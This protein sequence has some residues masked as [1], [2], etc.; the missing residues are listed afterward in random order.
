MQQPFDQIAIDYDK[1]FTDTLV[2]K[3]QRDLVWS[4]LEKVLK[5][6]KITNVLEINCGTGEDALWLSQKGLNVIATDISEKMIES[7]NFKEKNN[8]NLVFQ[9]A[10]FQYISSFFPNKKFD[11]I[12]SNFGGINCTS[13]SNLRDWLNIEIPKMLNPNG[14]L[15]LVIMP[16]FC[17]IESI[18]F[19]GKLQFKNIFRRLSKKP[20]EAKLD[21]E[22]SIKTW[23]YSPKFIKKHLPKNLEIIDIQPI[24]FFIP[25][26]YL[27]SFV[28]KR[29]NLFKI[30][31]KLEK[32]VNLYSFLANFSDHYLIDIQMKK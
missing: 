18:Y 24:G 8:L 9:V 20:L 12:F 30:L 4:Y 13:P 17:L 22:T 23:Y 1:D 32:N 2:G 15:I 25:P 31:S 28:E 19:L 16:N 3:T 6:K 10:D 26:S 11:L 7:A 29:P 21:S 27:N 5:V 14:S